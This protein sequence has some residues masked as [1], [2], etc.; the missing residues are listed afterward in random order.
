MQVDER[1]APRVRPLRHNVPIEE[2]L[3]ARDEA[4]R[5]LL[6]H[7]ADVE[8]RRAVRCAGDAVAVG[9]VGAMEIRDESSARAIPAYGSNIDRGCR[10]TDT[11]RSAK[12]SRTC[13]G[14]KDQKITGCFE[15]R[16]IILTPPRYK[17]STRSILDHL[18]LKTGMNGKILPIPLGERCTPSLCMLNFTSG[19]VAFPPV[20]HL[21]LPKPFGQRIPPTK[22]ISDVPF[23]SSRDAVCLLIWA[24]SIHDLSPDCV[25]ATQMYAFRQ[26]IL[27]QG[28]YFLLFQR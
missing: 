7:P 5:V 24:F 16:G 27:T 13:I 28:S 11:L 26:Q 20:F 1:V 3:A 10:S 23:T 2:V 12:T 25:T 17:H 21:V 8:R 6:V 18:K 22:A 4:W 15:E 9:I 19:H 14:L